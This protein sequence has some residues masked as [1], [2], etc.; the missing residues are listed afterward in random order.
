MHVTNSQTDK[1]NGC[2]TNVTALYNGERYWLKNWHILVEDFVI[3]NTLEFWGSEKEAYG[4]K[5]ATAI[6]HLHC[7]LVVANNRMTK[8]RCMKDCVTPNNNPIRLPQTLTKLQTLWVHCATVNIAVSNGCT[9]FRNRST[10]MQK[11][12]SD[13]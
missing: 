11:T 1:I 3:K 6:T 10:K 2:P 9:S 7:S 8:G 12:M 5:C 13:K 4:V